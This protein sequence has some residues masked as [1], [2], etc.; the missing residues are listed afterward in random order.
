MIAEQGILP[1][2][3]DGI[4]YTFIILAFVLPQI[5][6]FMVPPD[7]IPAEERNCAWEAARKFVYKSTVERMLIRNWSIRQSVIGP[8]YYEIHP[9]TFFALPWREVISQCTYSL[10]EGTFSPEKAWP[11][12]V[13]F[14]R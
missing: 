12:D 13:P 8:F 1:K 2:V 10:K 7:P 5:E 4:F 11:P 6:I 3:I 14:K 9:V